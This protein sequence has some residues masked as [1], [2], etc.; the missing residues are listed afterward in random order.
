MPLSA[1]E[2]IDKLTRALEM[3][4]EMSLTLI[5]LLADAGP[6]DGLEEHKRMDIVRQLMEIKHETNMHK[7]MVGDLINRLKSG[8]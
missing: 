8:G 4:E 5:D 2:T 6:V 3:E 7:D 1:G